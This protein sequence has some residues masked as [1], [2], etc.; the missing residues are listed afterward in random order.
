MKAKHLMLLAAA[1]LAACAANASRPGTGVELY[2]G[3]FTTGFEVSDFRRCGSQESWWV[4]GNMGPVSRFVSTLPEMERRGYPTLYVE[5][6]GEVS[7][8]GSY[9][10][11]GR[12]PREI[13][14]D[15][16][17]EVR[18]EGPADCR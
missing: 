14:V 5:W 6:R 12:Y 13:R 7:A 10:H 15:T 3:H 8:P 16:V 11:L 17:L 9:G 1:P 2:R 18:R 4:G